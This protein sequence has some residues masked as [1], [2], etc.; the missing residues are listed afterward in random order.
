MAIAVARMEDA[1]PLV[2]TAFLGGMAQSYAVRKYPEW[3][4]ALSLALMGIGVYAATKG[5]M[6]TPVG[7]GLATA[8]SAGLGMALMPVTGATRT[9]GGSRQ[10]A[11]RMAGVANL[12]GSGGSVATEPVRVT[13]SYPI[14]RVA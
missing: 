3:S 13:D 14:Y 1:I 12:I 4:W 5:G 11:T 2:G 9:G 7:L 10:L 8:A 6:F